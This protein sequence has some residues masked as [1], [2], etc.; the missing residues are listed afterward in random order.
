MVICGVILYGSYNK[1]V[2]GSFTKS[3]FD[4]YAD[5][6]APFHRYGFN[7]WIKYRDQ[8]NGPRVDRAWN[9]HYHNHT[10]MDGL[11]ISG[12]RL[13][14]FIEWIFPGMF[15]S[16][17][18]I[19]MW[20]FYLRGEDPRHGLIFSIFVS[21]Q[22]I[23]VPHWYPGMLI[24]GSNYLYEASPLFILLTARG[25]IT[26]VDKIANQNRFKRLIIPFTLLALFTQSALFM[27][28]RMTDLHNQKSVALWADKTI[29]ALPTHKRL[30]FVR[31]GPSHSIF[32]DFIH[33]VPTLDS[34]TILARD[35]GEENRKLRKYFPDYP[36]YILDTEDWTVKQLSY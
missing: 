24:F 18:L 28:E 20:I 13:E 15:L 14:Y 35:R 10:F 5:I 30:V 2:T 33:N 16:L 19:L 7:T 32:Q 3:P 4:L 12:A 22:M 9:E 11:I 21:L 1:A 26:S 6:H 29:S 31:N 23:Y 27:R 8:A 36:F 34:P 17:F 25:L